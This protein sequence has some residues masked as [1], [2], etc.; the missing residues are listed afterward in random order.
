MCYT[1]QAFPPVAA[2]L[3]YMKLKSIA[4]VKNLRGKKVLLRLDCNVPLRGGK[5]A[6]D[7]KITRSLPTIQ[8]LLERGARVIIVSHLGRPKGAEKKLSL[9]PAQK[10]LE[11]LLGQKVELAPLARVEH[12]EI[13]DRMKSGEAA[14]LENIRFLPGEEKNDTTLSK[15]LAKIA[16]LF[17]L[18]GFAV[19]HRAAASVAGVAKYAPS[20]A[21]LLLSAEIAALSKI[22][23][24]PRRP[25]VMILG[26]AKPETKIPVLEFFLSKADAILL[27]GTV[28]VEYFTALSGKKSFFTP[29]LIRRIESA[30]RAGKII[31]PVDAVVGAKDGAEA[32]LISAAE[33]Q[34]SLSAGGIRKEM[35]DIG[36]ATTQLFA[37]RIKRAQTLIW[38]GAMGKFEVPV[39]SHATKAI[40]RLF[41][42]RSKGHAFGV[43]GGGETVEVIRSLGLLSDIDLVSTGGGAMLEFL[44]GKKLPGLAALRKK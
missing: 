27:C 22:T 21:G 31:M 35:Y 14:M 43:C 42:G 37:S 24:K 18:D 3:V 44:S 29:A 23:T 19:A 32:E 36:P 4:E 13:F 6:D 34:R 28:A 15:Q 12:P 8:Y 9:R 7:F 16:D 2:F 17:V 1:R 25:L 39:Y 11:K 40:A 20:Y 26:G 38:N 33:F 5:I 41:V 30:S 10:L